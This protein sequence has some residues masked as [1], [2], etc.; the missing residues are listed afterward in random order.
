MAEA[1][2]LGHPAPPSVV[3]L[4]RHPALVA[5]CA[6]LALVEAIVLVAY[7]LPTGVA[8]SP[9]L[10]AA[11][12]F[13]VFHDLRWLMVF[14]AGYWQFALLLVALFVLRATIVTVLVSLA[15]PHDL[16]PP[17]LR[18]TFVN[19]LGFVAVSLVLL[20][21]AA[22]SLFTGAVTSLWEFFLAAFAMAVLPLAL[23][24][25]LA[26]P[27]WW[28]HLPPWRGFAW[29]IIDGAALTLTSLA[30]SY[31]PGWVALAPA[32]AGG[33]FNALVWLAMTE[34]AA[35]RIHGGQPR[36]VRLRW[37]GAATVGA[38]L[39]TAAGFAVALWTS[40]GTVPRPSTYAARQPVID[41]RGFRSHYAGHSGNPLG[42]GYIYQRFSY[43][44]LSASGAPR[45]YTARDTYQ[46]L[47]RSAALLAVQV[48]RL[49]AR[50]HSRI[51]L[52]AD[53]EGAMTAKLYLLTHPRAPVKK[54]VM[55]SPIIRPGRV[56]Y[57]P[58]GADTWGIAT[59]FALRREASLLSTA[60]PVSVQTPLLRSMVWDAPILRGRMLCPVP[61][62]AQSAFIPLVNAIAEPPPVNSG[63]PLTVLPTVHGNV[64]G[65]GRDA[66]WLALTPGHVPQ[67]GAW[68]TTAQWVRAAA[69]GW[70]T[71]SLPLGL[72]WPAGATTTTNCRRN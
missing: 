9:Q 42:H 35:H 66:R 54:L 72:G 60:F 11:P 49:Y 22:T 62:V 44:G 52:L 28:R 46:S 65:P 21:P 58:E 61:G 15:W 64:S 25:Y 26:F 38:C 20:T 34:T 4:R 53:S 36:P 70:Q 39:A 48:H 17:P 31:A 56:Y 16:P 1:G 33:A 68:Q 37:T 23:L 40:S 12:A 14:H 3:R 67:F 27:G 51:D 43:A 5:V 18:R 29:V 2:H 50:T 24:W 41:L 71:P 30:I 59:R 63:I 47:S 10:S 55:T 32:T 19:A 57:P 45:P 8:L 69:A 13:G 6:G 7:H